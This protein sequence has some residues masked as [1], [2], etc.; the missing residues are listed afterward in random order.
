MNI[1]EKN[2]LGVNLLE[3]GIL[4]LYLKSIGVFIATNVFFIG[5]NGSR[6]QFIQPFGIFPPL[7]S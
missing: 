2:I 5:C 4:L 3:I 6:G 1:D 7:F